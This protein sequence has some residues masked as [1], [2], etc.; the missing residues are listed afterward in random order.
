MREIRFIEIS[1]SDFET[2]LKAAGVP[3]EAISMLLYLFG[4]VLDGRNQYITHGIEDALG[5]PAKNFDQFH[6]LSRDQHLRPVWCGVAPYHFAGIPF[7]GFYTDAAGNKYV[8][9]A[10]RCSRKKNRSL[11][12]LAC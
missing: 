3:E 7:A 11:A 12:H 6:S 9:V 5:R 2:N 10:D 1:M 8:P 4:E